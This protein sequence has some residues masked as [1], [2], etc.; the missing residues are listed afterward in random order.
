MLRQQGDLIT[1]SQALAA[2][3]T[4]AALRHRLRADG[5]WM[6]VLPGIYLAH[7][8][9]L[10]VGQREIAATLY[11][12]R[13]CV[14]T[15][16]AALRRQGVRVPLS[17]IVDVLI[18]EATK[19]QSKGFVRLHRTRR[20]PEQPWMIDGIRY[21]PTARAVA[22]AVSD[23]EDQRAVSALVASAVQ[24]RTCSVQELIA[25]L[26]A[27]SKQGSGALR[28]ALAEVADGIASVAEADL[29]QLIKR[30]GLPEPMYNPKL[31][32]GAEFIAK[33]DA[34][35]PDAGVACEVDSRE[36][37]LSPAGWEK[38]LIRHA[39]MSAHGIIV[40]HFTPRRLRAA[41]A[42]VASQLRLALDEG[43]KRAPL[44]I[45]AITVR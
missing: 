13:G 17:G 3:L 36:W 34:W 2:G 41:S 10:T 44:P 29:R 22:D 23:M 11:A 31:Y 28:A 20:M 24:Q 43:R 12:G 6:V 42:E 25:E 37:H 27:G 33:P 21:A 14:I 40:L 45:R 32:V 39:K 19:R 5:P 35:W 18:P 1:R 8:G 38:T 26:R 16:S 7:N 30:N 15:G 4:D 9:P